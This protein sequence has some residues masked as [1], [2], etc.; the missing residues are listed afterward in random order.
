[1]KPTHKPT[2]K[3]IWNA[4]S[5]Y[6]TCEK[7]FAAY[8]VF[9]YLLVWPRICIEAVSFPTEWLNEIIMIK[10][11]PL[12]IIVS[13]LSN[14]LLSQISSKKLGKTMALLPKR[15][16]VSL[17]R[18]ISRNKSGAICLYSTIL[19]IIWVICLW[20]EPVWSPRFWK[21]WIWLEG[22]I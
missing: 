14:V 16:F 3:L 7:I 20:K 19:C 12:H 21:F 18:E 17:Q 22:G 4:Q 6:L 5:R 13:N 9:A 1:M 10:L 2:P 11:T 15:P 8:L